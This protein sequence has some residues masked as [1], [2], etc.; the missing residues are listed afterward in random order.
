[1]AEF[2]KEG[3]LSITGTIITTG[4]TNVAQVLNK[5]FS[6]RFNNPAAYV[7]TLELYDTAT[8][9]TTT[10]YSLALSAGD[11]VTDNLTYA[12][13]PGYQLIAT[14]NIIGTTYYAYGI[15]Y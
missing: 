4:T 11:T 14:S 2:I 1:M 6:L 9:N 5:V 3:E 7:L 8:S 15:N 13:K 12:L 10:L